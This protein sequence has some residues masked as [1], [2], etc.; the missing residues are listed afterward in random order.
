M[1]W[2][3]NTPLASFIDNVVVHAELLNVVNHK[4]THDWGGECAHTV[5]IRIRHDARAL[6]CCAVKRINII[7]MWTGAYTVVQG[8]T[9]KNKLHIT[10]LDHQFVE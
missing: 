10:K 2:G 1:V 7:D 6:V 5:Q 8:I 4:H 9:Q 3:A